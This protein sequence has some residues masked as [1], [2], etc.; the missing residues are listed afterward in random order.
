MN[1]FHYASAFVVQFR[2]ATDFGANHVE[3]RIEHIASGRTAH[4]EST[5]E[6][7]AVIERMWTNALSDRPARDVDEGS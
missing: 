4:F 7:L 1:D 6:L 5:S 2:T 3:G